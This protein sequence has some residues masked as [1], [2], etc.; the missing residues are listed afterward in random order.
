MHPLSNI[1]HPPATLTEHPRVPV[2]TLRIGQCYVHE[3]G[4]VK[5]TV[6]NRTRDYITVVRHDATGDWYTRITPDMKGWSAMV[7]VTEGVRKTKARAA[8]SAQRELFV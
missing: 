2:H 6:Y 1:Y 7:I 4:G 5:R 8:E 3:V